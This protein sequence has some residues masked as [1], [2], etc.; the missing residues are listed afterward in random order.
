MMV[1]VGGG[2]PTVLA[3]AQSDPLNIAVDASNVYWT[4]NNGANGDAVMKI[5]L[6]GGVPILLATGASRGS[7]LA[8]DRSTVYYANFN[9]GALMAVPIA[10]GT[11]V[12]LSAQGAMSSSLQTRTT[13]SP[14]IDKRLAGLEHVLDALDGCRRSAQ[15]EE[16][17]HLKLKHRPLVDGMRGR[18]RGAAGE[19][20]R[21][22]ASDER[23]VL[24][25][26]LGG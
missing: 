19:N 11:P 9:G 5:S 16:G 14:L 17:F 23:A 8:L 12:T 7:S 18:R 26:F 24:G 21:L 20:A 1:P 15:R 3:S 10:G 6:E 13:S 2:T 22:M 25:D 4:A